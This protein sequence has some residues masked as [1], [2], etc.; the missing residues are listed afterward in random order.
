M[1]V[2]PEFRLVQALSISLLLAVLVTALLTPLLLVLYRR[3]VSALMARKAGEAAPAPAALVAAGLP[4]ALPAGGDLRRRSSAIVAQRARAWFLGFAAQALLLTLL[5]A[6]SYANAL[7]APALLLALLT[8]LLPAVLVLLSV[9]SASGWTRLLVVAGGL[10][11][12]LAWPGAQGELLRSVARLYVGLPLLPLLLFQLRFWRGVAAELF[13]LGLL[14][15]AGWMLT[16]VLARD[17]LALGEGGALWMLRLLGLV[18]GL[19]AGLALLRALAARHARGRL[20][21]Q[22]F[23]L[24]IWWLLY[25]LVQATIVA[26]GLVA[27]AGLVAL[28]GFALGR[29]ITA[30]LLRRGPGRAG[31]PQPE[32]PRRLLLLRVFGNSR[33]SE[34]LFEQ[35]VQAWTPLGSIELIGG[36]RSG[37]H[38][39][40]APRFPGLP[41]RPTARSLR[42]ESRRD[43]CPPGRADH[44]GGRWQLSRPA[45]LLPCRCLGGHDAADAGGFRCGGDGS[46]PV[47]AGA[48][49]LPRRAG[50]PGSL[51]QPPTD[52]AGHRC[53]HRPDPG[54]AAAGAERR[55][56]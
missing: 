34:R 28:V 52:R 13:L 33:R 25:S 37:P 24:S 45:D 53:Q 51:G 22:S 56:S 54:A 16:Y 32:P 38:A 10:L 23:S 4:A 40:D 36:T 12:V 5:F 35:L 7:S 41:Y 46:A 27:W 55:R 6:V 42:P 15:G 43:G 47:P 31:L 39:G 44:A 9:I 17:G 14:A 19:A 20:S 18:A 29:A 1:N 2:S 8:F 49:R 21:E 3:R 50:R 48:I 26:I 30:G 11:L